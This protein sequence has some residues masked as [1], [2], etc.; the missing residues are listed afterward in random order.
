MP[1]IT[2]MELLSLTATWFQLPWY[3]DIVVFLRSPNQPAFTPPTISEPDLVGV[4]NSA[5]VLQWC[6]FS[7]PALK[8]QVKTCKIFIQLKIICFNLALN[9]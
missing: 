9:F 8:E 5:D 1:P 4:S 7:L 6:G 3:S 2:T